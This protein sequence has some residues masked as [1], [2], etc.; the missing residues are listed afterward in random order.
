MNA[1]DIYVECLALM[2]KNFDGEHEKVKSLALIG[3]EIT[4]ESKEVDLDWKNPMARPPV[5]SLIS[6]NVLN[7]LPYLIQP[8]NSKLMCVTAICC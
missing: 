4:T 2:K 3:Q 6:T 1:K 8:F 5:F 7:E